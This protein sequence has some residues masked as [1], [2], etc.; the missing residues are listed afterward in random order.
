M[1]DRSILSGDFVNLRYFQTI[2]RICT[3]KLKK[4][5]NV[6]QMR[7]TKYIQEREDP[8]KTFQLR[9]QKPQEKERKGTTKA[10][11]STDC[12]QSA[13]IVHKRRVST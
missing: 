6:H 12:F 8:A 10:S 5:K 9:T 1:I 7:S 4:G 3:T 11:I 2:N 13:K